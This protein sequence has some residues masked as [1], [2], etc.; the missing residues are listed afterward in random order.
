VIEESFREREDAIGMLSYLFVFGLVTLA[1][2]WWQHKNENLNA[3]NEQRR[4]A[5]RESTNSTNSVVVD[6][7]A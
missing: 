5:C 4:P 7:S 2:W 1:F 3:K 6:D